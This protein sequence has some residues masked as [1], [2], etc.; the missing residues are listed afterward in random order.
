[1]GHVNQSRLILG[2]YEEFRDR[3][4]AWRVNT[5]KNPVQL[6]LA[7]GKLPWVTAM[8]QAGRMGLH[9][10]KTDRLC[11]RE[12]ESRRGPETGRQFAPAIGVA[13]RR[14][15]SVG[16][17]PGTSDRTTSNEDTDEATVRMMCKG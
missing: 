17:G 14:W 5:R 12:P 10:R 16:S 4:L 8:F 11:L 1:M 13:G 15:P 9:N 3:H 7:E 2:V 6:R